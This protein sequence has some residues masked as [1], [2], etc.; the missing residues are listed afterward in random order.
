MHCASRLF[1]GMFFF[2][3]CIFCRSFCLDCNVATQC[4]S[5]K[6]A[7]LRVDNRFCWIELLFSALFCRVEVS[8]TQYSGAKL[9]HCALCVRSRARTFSTFSS[10]RGM[11]GSGRDFVDDA[12]MRLFSGERRAFQFL[13]AESAVFYWTPFP[14]PLEHFI[15]AQRKK[16]LRHAMQRAFF[17]RM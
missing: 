13:C 8:A 3:V 17:C 11:R 6:F 14:P 10:E 4:D 2:G 1:A 9:Q 7:H 5:V 16:L 15:A 12:P